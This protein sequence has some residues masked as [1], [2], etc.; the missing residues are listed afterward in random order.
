M[1][2]SARLIQR[3]SPRPEDS[4]C[5]SLIEVD[6][7]ALALAI[8]KYQR[9]TDAFVEE[10]RR[11]RNFTAFGGSEEV[12]V[13]SFDSNSGARLWI[14]HYDIFDLGDV[15]GWRGAD[16]FIGRIVW[17]ETCNLDRG[18]LQRAHDGWQTEL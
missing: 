8:S 14:W 2:S 17:H 12:G 3:D 11:V 18:T 13:D 1:K 4:I 5:E 10:M 7:I 16:L 6:R 9:L 15:F